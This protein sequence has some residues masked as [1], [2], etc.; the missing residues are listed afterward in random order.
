MERERARDTE[1]G[2]GKR[3]NSERRRTMEKE[4][5]KGELERYEGK[6][7]KPVSERQSIYNV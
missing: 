7:S 2:E 1:R 5:Q 6:S 4:R 3:Q